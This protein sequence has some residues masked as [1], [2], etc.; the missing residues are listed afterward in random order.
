MVERTK[1]PRGRP[2]CDQNL[3]VDSEARTNKCT[4]VIVK[5]C[6]SMMYSSNCTAIRVSYPRLRTKITIHF[7]AF[8]FFVRAKHVR[9][10]RAK[11]SRILSASHSAAFRNNLVLEWPSLGHSRTSIRKSIR[12]SF[13]D[14]DNAAF[15]SRHEKSRP[16]CCLSLLLPLACQ[17]DCLPTSCRLFL[18]C[19]SRPTQYLYPR[20][21]R[22]SIR[23]FFWRKVF[24]A[25]Q[26]PNF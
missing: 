12:N 20:H 13:A 24:G 7:I 5:V 25:R 4:E 17:R 1:A 15:C 11:H 23:N 21:T 9:R 2:K 19:R 8:T 3:F 22:S 16:A 6:A 10:T 14:F 26:S 18:R